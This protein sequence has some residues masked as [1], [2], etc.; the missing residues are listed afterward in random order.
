MKDYKKKG[1]ENSFEVTY[2]YDLSSDILGIKVKR[3]FIYNETV[4]IKEGLLLDF[5]K[6]NVPVSLEIHDASKLFNIPKHSLKKPFLFNMDIAVN[7]KFI[8]LII[9]VG[10]LIHNKENKQII[11]EYTLNRYNIPNIETELYVL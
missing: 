11:E 2:K 1:N 3:D 9:S 6:D 7:E 4:E 5:D 10:F 8:T